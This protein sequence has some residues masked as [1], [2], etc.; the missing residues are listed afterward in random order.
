MS[1]SS[2]QTLSTQRSLSGT[3][4]EQ[5]FFQMAAMCVA[6]SGLFL[7]CT[8]PTIVMLIGKPY[9]NVPSGGNAAYEVK[10]R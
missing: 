8:A 3:T 6:A 5:Q 7:V 4:Q 9:W 10:T 1:N 2:R